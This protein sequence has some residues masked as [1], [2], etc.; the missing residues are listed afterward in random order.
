VA[1]KRSKIT[2]KLIENWNKD[3][4]FVCGRKNVSDQH[5]IIPVEYNGPKKGLTVPLCPTDHRSI[6]REAEN[7][8]KNDEIGE[9]INRRLYPIKE[10]FDRAKFLS[11]Y[12]VTAKKRFIASG[13]NKA[14]TAR[15]MMQVS[16]SS[17]ELKIAH[18][19]KRK[20]GFNSLTRMVKFLI[21]DTWNKK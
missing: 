11:D 5:H 16:L 12:I 2:R 18:D 20:L 21:L 9:F 8:V 1:K 7:I 6:H 19:L 14:E 17:Q 13:S 10:H 15:N 3:T 4:C